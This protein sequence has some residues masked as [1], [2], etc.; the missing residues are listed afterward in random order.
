MEIPADVSRGRLVTLL[1]CFLSLHGSATI[2]TVNVVDFCGQTIRGDG[3]IINSHQESKKY[4]FVTMG[5]DCHLTMQGSS[6]KDKVQFHFRFF[7][8][9]SLLR[10]APLSPAPLLALDAKVE[11][12]SGESSGG[13]PCHAGSFVQFY[14]GRDRSS[15][16]LGPPLCGKSPPRPVLSTGNY[17]TLRLVTR[18]TQPRVDFVGDFTS[19]RLGFNH[20]LCSSE[21]YFTCRNGKCIPLSL[22]CD[23]KGID[24]CGDGS[25]LEENLTTGCKAGQLVAAEQ[26][27]TAVATPPP[28]PSFVNS[29][30]VPT[31]FNC[32]I[33]HST[34][35]Y[36][37]VSDSPASVSLWV[38][39]M[40]V[41][42]LV[43]SAVLCWCCWSPGWFLWR[44]SIFRFLSRCNSPCA[45]CQLCVNSCA[46]SKE[47]RLA[48]VS[49]QPPPNG[50]LVTD[51]DERLS[52]AA[53]AAGL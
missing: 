39:F 19:F 51:A 24:N 9:Y 21:P 5:T 10:V 28:P 17:L 37:S 34:P 30:T 2:D 14:D 44:I 22:V 36:E 4:Y 47:Q 35:S 26:P 46:S 11:P 6:P 18:G 1:L 52:A 48:K 7:L 8:V 41:G 12:T 32:G 25:D 3:M 15:P 16:L 13:D 23:D 40:I 45:S 38:L 49:P 27:A 50:V 43:G 42:V 33:P 29:P 31:H 20:S 53:A